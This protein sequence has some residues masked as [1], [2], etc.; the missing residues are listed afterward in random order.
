VVALVGA[1]IAIEGDHLLVW[2]FV[3]VI[4]GLQ[5]EFRASFDESPLNV[6]YH[7]YVLPAA[8]VAAPFIWY[9]ALPLSTT[10][11]PICTQLAL[12]PHG[13]EG[14]VALASA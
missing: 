8:T 9:V 13:G 2:T 6:A 7:Q 1:L 14:D 3:V 11:V 4:D 10:A 12:L 5:R